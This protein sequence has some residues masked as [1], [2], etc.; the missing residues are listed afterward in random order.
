MEMMEQLKRE[1]QG[2]E[3]EL[4]ERQQSVSPPQP[5][6]KLSSRLHNMFTIYQE[7]QLFFRKFRPITTPRYRQRREQTIS[8]LSCQKFVAEKYGGK[9]R[10]I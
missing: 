3:K 10:E 6:V 4:S 9:E 7:I 1:L 8:G 5:P 2:K